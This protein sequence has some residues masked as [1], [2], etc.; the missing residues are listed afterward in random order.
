MEAAGFG[1][2]ILLLTVVRVD[3]AVLTALAERWWDTTN[4]FHFQFEEMTVT[5]LDFAAITGLRVGGEPIPYDASLVLDDSALL[6]FLGRVPRQSGG[7]AAYGQF[8]EYWDHEPADDEEAARMARAY[9]LYLFGASLY[10]NRRSRV[11]LSYLA[12]LVDLRQAGRFD[13][14]GSA[15]CTLYC[16]LGASSRGVGNTVGGY[17]RVVEV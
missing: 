10:P 5:P 16:L 8:V 11:H 9:L 14:G 15:L 12:G 7:M 13:W 6:W 17:W 1:P 2:F 3:R 4:T